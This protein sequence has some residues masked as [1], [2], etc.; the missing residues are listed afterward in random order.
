MKLTGGVIGLTQNPAALHRSCLVTTYFL[1][2]LSKEFCNKNQITS[3]GHAQHYQITGSTNQTISTNV[4]KMIKYL[5]RLTLILRK[6]DQSSMSFQKPSC[7]LKLLQI[8]CVMKILAKKCID[9]LL[10]I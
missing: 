2:A 4:K 10:M 3:Q 9:L 8:Y 5:I 6:T 7:L 1:S